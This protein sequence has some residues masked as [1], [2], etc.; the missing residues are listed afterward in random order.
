MSLF[1]KLTELHGTCL[2]M[3]NVSKTERGDRG[4]MMELFFCLWHTPCSG[5]RAR[6][7]QIR[8]LV[9]QSLL[10]QDTELQVAPDVFVSVNVCVIR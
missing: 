4:I 1:L 3:L 9:I 8:M 10:G 2:I 5:G 6:H 7:L